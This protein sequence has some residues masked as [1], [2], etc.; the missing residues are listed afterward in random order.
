MRDKILFLEEAHEPINKVY[1][2]L[3]HLKL[4]VS[5]MIV[6][7]WLWESVQVVRWLTG[8]HTRM[9]SEFLVSSESH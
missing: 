2:Y 9:I 5:L 8:N 3:N 4:A 1:R 7:V 6:S